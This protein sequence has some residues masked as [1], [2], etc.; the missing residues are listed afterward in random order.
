MIYLSFN[1]LPFD[2]ELET[3][4]DDGDGL[5]WGEDWIEEEYM[6]EEL[7]SEEDE[8][9][10]EDKMKEEYLEEDLINEEKMEEDSSQRQSSVGFT[11]TGIKTPVFDTDYFWKQILPV[12]DDE[13]SDMP[14]LELLLE[15]EDEYEITVNIDFI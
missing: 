9:K 8:K 10:I 5:D 3:L 1:Q 2:I 7:E 15:N 12:D 6:I 13:D 11:L 4:E 14:G